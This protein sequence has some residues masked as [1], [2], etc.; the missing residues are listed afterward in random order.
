MLLIN[1]DLNYSRLVM[2]DFPGARGGEGVSRADLI[3]TTGDRI[4]LE[5]LDKEVG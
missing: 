3:P 5:P 2:D 4:G 1:F